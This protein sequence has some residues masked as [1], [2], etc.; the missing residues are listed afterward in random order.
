MVILPE[1]IP[2]FTYDFNEDRIK[3]YEESLIISGL[4]RAINDLSSEIHSLNKKT[5]LKGIKYQEHSI[6]LEVNNQII[7]ALVT[8]AETFEQ[9]H[10]LRIFAN[11]LTQESHLFVYPQKVTD[12][13]V[14]T[15]LKLTKDIF[16][17]YTNVSS[18]A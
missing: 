14:Q 2:L 16:R 5:S 18:D 9:R 10:M 4:L 17:P 3:A 1:G 11:K 8:S 7:Y 13:S 12:L 6:L 15:F